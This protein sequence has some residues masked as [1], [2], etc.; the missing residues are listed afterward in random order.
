MIWVLLS[1]TEDVISYKD[2]T[3]R[4]EVVADTGLDDTDTDDTV[5]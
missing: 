3:S 4:D 5:R 1:C 2:I